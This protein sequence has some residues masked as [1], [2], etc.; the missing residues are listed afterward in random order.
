MIPLFKVGMSDDVTEKVGKILHSGYITEGPQVQKFESNLTKMINHNHI[1]TVNSCTNGLTLALRLLKD[2]LKWDHGQDIVLTTPFTCFATNAPILTQNM[3]L[4]WVDINPMTA[5]MSLTDLKKKLSKRTKI[6]MLVHWGGVSFAL[7]QLEAVLN[8]FEALHGFRPWVIEDAAH[9][10]YA[11][12]A[13]GNFIGQCRKNHMVVFSFQA[14]KLLTTVDGG[15]LCVPSKELEEKAKLLRWFGID[16]E[17]R[18]GNGF[19]MEP[20]II[21]AGYKFHMNDVNATIGLCNLQL[22]PNY[23]RKNVENV[24]CL[25]KC[26][27][28]LHTI[29]NLVV[30]GKPSWWLFTV[31]TSFKEELSSWLSSHNISN[32]QV[33]RRNDTNSCVKKYHEVLPGVDQA[34]KT[35][36]CIPCGWWLSSNDIN[37]I[38]KALETFDIMKRPRSSYLYRDLNYL[39]LLRGILC[40]VKPKKAI[41]FG[42]LDGCST[43]ILADHCDL[44]KAYD[45][46][47]D[48]IGN[49]ANE[50]IIRK[51]FENDKHVSIYR[52]SMYE[53]NLHDNSVD[54]IHVDVANDGEVYEY[55]LNTFW[56]ALKKGGILVLEGGSLERDAVPWMDQYRKK[57]ISH[58]LKSNCVYDHNVIGTHPSVT[59]F[60]KE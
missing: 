41:E 44:V 45:I 34:E 46:F 14:I 7:E 39:D 8:E 12:D 33:H 23:H 57:S 20:D 30:R 32:S 54:F 43:R 5:M 9:A 38:T 27:K 40:S 16:R 36:L 35:L 49:H 21:S 29:N 48:F 53:I 60:R 47:D 15:A 24:E 42:I 59:V 58:F 4:K 22:I 11:K 10:F 51:Q 13:S 31:S 6:I 1:V 28:S 25:S 37:N 3:N 52:K 50:N 18:S 17:K 26:V 19:R 55:V 2:E 56:S